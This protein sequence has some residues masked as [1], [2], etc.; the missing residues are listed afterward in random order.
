MPEPLVSVDM[1]TYNH[2]PYIGRAIEGVLGQKTNFPF[3]IV[4]GE[5]CSTDGTREIVFEYQKKYPDV[6]RVITSEKNIGA[7][8][9]CKRTFGACRG[10]Y[11]AD[12]EG[13]DYWHNP[14]KLQK[15]V[16]Y[17]ESHP[18]CGL[19]FSDF[20]IYDVK[21]KKT[22]ESFFKSKGYYYPKNPTIEYFIQQKTI[23]PLSC[24]VMVRRELL[25]R[26]TNADPVLY[27]SGRFMMG[28]TPV[29]VEISALADVAY[30]DESLATYNHLVESASRSTDI[31][32]RLRFT[33]SCC[34]MRMYLWDKYNLPYDDIRK[35]FE[36]LWCQYALRL[37][38]YERNTA[39]A[40]E[41][42]NKKSKFTFLEWLKY[43]GSKNT[44]LYYL[45]KTVI[46]YRDIYLSLNTGAGIGF[47]GE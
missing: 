22:T 15:Q 43:F 35:G 34:D 9:N 28:D 12:C 38:F 24:T 26:I 42:R 5:D 21:T 45:L 8:E 2:A 36:E 11:V 19:V 47:T 37:A 6:I 7:N 16:D 33:V 17:M 29:W 40:D 32:R 25:Q 18:E 39:L 44:I 30:I 31:R 41:I 1:I 3:E 46:I 10:K 20:D 13:D 23:Y 27:Q 14:N 4:V